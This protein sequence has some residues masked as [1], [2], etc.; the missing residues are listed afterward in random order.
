MPSSYDELKM[1]IK[2]WERMF[3]R[4]HK[5][6]PG[7]LDIKNAPTEIQQCYKEYMAL[8][9]EKALES[10]GIDVFGSH[11]NKP[12]V[13]V[14]QAEQ[15]ENL[16]AI[17]PNLRKKFD[18]KKPKARR[19][20]EKETEESLVNSFGLDS[21]FSLE[22]RT[23]CAPVLPTKTSSFF[24]KTSTNILKNLEIQQN[25]ISGGFS[26]QEVRS[27]RQDRASDKITEQKIVPENHS[28]CLDE[29]VGDEAAILK[30]FQG[31]G[32]SFD[33]FEL[34]EDNH[35]HNCSLKA[36]NTLSGPSPK[37]NDGQPSQLLGESSL[38]INEDLLNQKQVSVF[39]DCY[40]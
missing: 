34:T 4:Q 27:Q 9:K 10:S 15:K 32:S 2:C 6:K 33:V 18:I 23:N 35:N 39:K 13:T 30:N 31:K 17:K 29:P 20:E 12:K 22:D 28:T 1:D 36:S 14:E 38:S 40:F 5:R 11:L 21:S 25:D 8:K 3:E 19:V 16:V 37:I 7:K 24:A 26:F